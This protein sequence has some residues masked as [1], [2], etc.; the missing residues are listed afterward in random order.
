MRFFAVFLACVLLTGGWVRATRHELWLYASTNLQVDDNAN[1]LEALLRRAHSAGYEA[2]VLTD[3][4]FGRLADVTDR[5]RAN[6]RRIR[7]VAQEL[8]LRL[9]PAVAPI[10]YSNDLLYHDPNLAEGLVVEGTPLEVRNGV[11]RL[12]PDLSV[13]FGPKLSFV[14]DTVRIA[15]GVATVTDPH[16][17]SRF[18]YALKLQPHRC[19]RV[20]VDIRTDHFMAKPEIKALAKAN[21]RSLQ[22]QS[23]GV[24]PTQDWKRVYVAFNTLDAADVNVYFGVW[25]DAKGTLQWRNWTIE[26]VALLNVLRRDGAPLKVVDERT[27]KSLIERRD[28]E[29]WADPKLGVTPWPGEYEW[30]HEPPVLRVPKLP[31][32]TKLRV[33]WYHPAIIYEGQVSICP[34]EPKTME[35]VA[36]QMRRVHELFG[37]TGYMLSHDEVRSLNTD[38][39]CLKQHKSPGELLGE[40]I[41][42]CRELLPKG[43]R[44]YVWSDMFDSDHNAVAGPYYLVNGDL[45]GSV[46]LLPKDVTVVNWNFDKRDTSLKFFAERGHRQVIAGYYDGDVGRIDAWLDS[47]D[48]VPGVDAVMYTTWERRYD[49]LEAFAQRVRAHEAK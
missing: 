21:G 45:R 10:G 47:A 14:D 31:D 46:E 33:S 49:D 30:A 44:A 5:Y 22:F 12:I 35:L 25:G 3:S 24:Q 34:S 29:R 43:T 6:A 41:A 37:A 2:C 16:S 40:N 38:E 42:R 4:K 9:V 26:E 8:G 23:L 19:Y 28:I 20:S 17:N 18:V 15:D 7:T 39:S 36:D 13:A 1:R 32:G 27:G 48:K 11:A